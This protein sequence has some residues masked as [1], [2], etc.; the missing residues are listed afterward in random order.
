VGHSQE[1]KAVTH[2]RILEVAS[3]RVREAGI[4]KPAIGELMKAANLT[5]GGFYRHF[6]SR[7][8]LVDEAIQRA[9]ADGA[10]RMADTVALDNGADAALHGLVE[11]Y[12]SEQHR[13]EVSGSCAV[14]TLASDVAR[15]SDR[16]RTAYT[17]QV[18]DYLEI[19]ESALDDPDPTRRRRQALV[20]LSAL[21]GAVLM[22][23][24]V[25]SP[26]LSRELL[27]EVA[28]AVTEPARP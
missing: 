28:A 19:I 24:A 12:L 27:T 3:A 4:E 2:R 5:H 11:A 16:A 14:A 20:D 8:D 1:D 22:A 21:V 13:D 17:R 10:A 23:R 25:N 9:L 18:E 7:E 15:A 26:S 6:S